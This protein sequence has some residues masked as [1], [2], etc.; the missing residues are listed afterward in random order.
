MEL[1]CPE[2]QRVAP[3]TKLCWSS[4]EDTHQQKM[5]IMK[6][7]S[8]SRWSQ[9]I[10]CAEENIYPRAKIIRKIFIDRRIV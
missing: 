1:G 5:R 3:Y 2:L 7:C 9:F 8:L 10:A 4:L 6:C